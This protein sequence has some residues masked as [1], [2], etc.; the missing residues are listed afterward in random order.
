MRRLLPLVAALV[1]AAG[2]G[3]LTSQAVGVSSQGPA[4]TVTINVPTGQTGPAGPAGPAGPPGP[5]GP[6]GAQ[7]CPAGYELGAVLINHPGG[8][9]TLWTCLK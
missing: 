9:V 2:A 3:F 1:F 8:Q 6:S 5:P 4:R 7:T